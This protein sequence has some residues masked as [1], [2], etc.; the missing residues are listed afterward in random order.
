M[1]KY[2]IFPKKYFVMVAVLLP[3]FMVACAEMRLNTLPTPPAD[4][5]A[6]CLHPTN[7]LTGRPMENSSPRVCKITDEIYSKIIR[8]N[9]DI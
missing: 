7:L 1:G 2:E 9:G 4:R 5:Q 3:I 8:T 6:A